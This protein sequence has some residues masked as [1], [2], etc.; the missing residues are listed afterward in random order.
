MYS[1]ALFFFF[2]I[3]K[4]TNILERGK[5]KRAPQKST[6]EVYKGAENGTKGGLRQKPTSP[7]AL[8]VAFVLGGWYMSLYASLFCFSFL[9]MLPDL[10]IYFSAYLSKKKKKKKQSTLSTLP[11]FLMS[12]LLLPRKEVEA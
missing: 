5:P 10:S 7:P 8:L 11:L 12:I 2:L 6:L 4:Q 1:P 3:G 9:C